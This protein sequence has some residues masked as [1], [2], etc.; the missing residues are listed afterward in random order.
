MANRASAS[1]APT[2]GP[3]AEVNTRRVLDAPP[4][5][6]ADRLSAT[7]SEVESAM[8]HRRRRT[9]LRDT[10]FSQEALNAFNSGDAHLRAAQ[11]GLARATEQYVKDIRDLT[12]KNTRLSQELEECMAQ[13]KAAL[14]A[15]GGATETPSDGAGL[16]PDKQHLLHQLKAGENVLTR[17]RQE[18]NNLQDSNTQLGEELKDVR[19][20]LS[21]S[22]KENWRLRHDIYSM[23]TG[24]PAEEM[25]GSTGDLLP[26]LLQLHERV[27]Q[28]M[29][30]VA[31]AWW[32]SISLPEDLGE[33][34][35][36]L[37]GA[38]RRFR[39]W[40]ISACRQGAREAWAMVKTRYTKAD[41]NH[42]AEVG[43]VGPDGK[44]IPVSLVYDQVEL[45]AKY[46]QRDCKLDSLLDG[47]EEEYNQSI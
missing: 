46:S 20:Q 7:N 1:Q 37:Q 6:D 45:A 30:G 43:P 47:I 26:E 28:V 10:C 25:P 2:P 11:D 13:L 44:E 40:K 14:A 41:P 42:M 9:V 31:Q 4:T 24:R 33:I 5:E 35:E 8:N 19:A 18:K 17:V 23:L 12:E 29:R 32:P 15:P 38:R 39:L 27:W 16:D 34:A 22:V 36:R 3:E 21:D